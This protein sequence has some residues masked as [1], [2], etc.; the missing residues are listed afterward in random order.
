VDDLNDHLDAGDS[1]LS[2]FWSHSPF[3]YLMCHR[4]LPF[5]STTAESSPTP[6][7]ASQV[8]LLINLF[9][10]NVLS[11]PTASGESNTPASDSM[12]SGG[13]GLMRW[14]FQLNNKIHLRRSELMIRLDMVNYIVLDNK[15]NVNYKTVMEYD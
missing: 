12:G 6:L 7:L 11:C 5:L 1:A 8:V 9:I 4:C 2:T 15:F 14:P 13:G 3:L 10:S